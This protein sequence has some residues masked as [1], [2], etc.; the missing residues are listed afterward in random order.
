[1]EITIIANTFHRPKEAARLV[2]CFLNRTYKKAKLW[3]MDSGGDFA[4]QE[5]EDWVLFH[6]DKELKNMAE[7]M[8]YCWAYSGKNTEFIATW[9]DDDIYFPYHLT[10]AMAALKTCDIALP[11]KVCIYHG[12]HYT[13]AKSSEKYDEGSWG[14]AW[15]FRAKYL[16]HFDCTHFNYDTRLLNRM[17]EKGARLGRFEISFPTY[18]WD[19][20]NEVDHASTGRYWNPAITAAGSLKLTPSF[21]KAYYALPIKGLF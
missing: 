19:Q 20:S 11:D 18:S 13:A 16:D 9:E 21:D 10:N 15:V 17:Q 6:P 12:D 14:D 2:Q 1:M 4:D 7:I 8:D 3:L 5:G